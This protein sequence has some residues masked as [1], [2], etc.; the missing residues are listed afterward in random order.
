MITKHG[1]FFTEPAQPLH[2]K[3]GSN[4]ESIATFIGKGVYTVKLIGIEFSQNGRK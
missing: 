3:L 2:Y 4:K 1:R